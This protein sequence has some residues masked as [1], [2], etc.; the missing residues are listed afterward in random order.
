MIRGTV[1]AAAHRVVNEVVNDLEM[2]TY[3]KH[4]GENWDCFLKIKEAYKADMKNTVEKI[5]SEWVNPYG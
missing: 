3:V 5:L 4:M 1:N 2:S